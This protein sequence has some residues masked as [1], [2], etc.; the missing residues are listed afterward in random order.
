VRRLACG[1]L[2]LLSAPSSAFP[3]L[4]LRP[5][6]TPFE[7]PADAAPTAIWWN[8]AALA[9]LSGLHFQVD[10][11][12]LAHRG[13]YDRAA[14]DTTTGLPSPTGDRTFPRVALDDDRF[15]YF[16]G[17]VWDLRSDT[18][19]LGLALHAPWDSTLALGGGN[20]LALP[21]SYHLVS[22]T[23]RNIYV[24]L[25]IALKLDPHWMVGLTISAVD[26]TTDLVFDRDTALDG[27]GAG[28]RSPSPRC[29]NQPCGFENPA[30]AARLH[31]HGD[32]GAIRIDGKDVLPVP[33]GLGMTWG[34]LTHYDR[35]WMGASWSHVFP[36]LGH[37]SGYEQ[38]YETPSA[39][40]AEL[41]PAPG[42]GPV[43]G[44]GPCRGGADIAYS[45]PDVF[46]LGARILLTETLELSTWG[47]L[48]LY[49][50]YGTSR[51][52]AF[53]GL[54]VHL[55]G[56]PVTQGGAPEQIVLARGLRPAFAAEVGLRWRPI[57]PVRIGLSFIGESS[58]VPSDYVSAAAIDAPKVDVTVAAE[59]RPRPFHVRGAEW[60]FHLGVSYGLTAL[61]PMQPSPGAFDPNAR[62]RCVDGSY[63][64]DACADD[65]AGKG[66]PNAAG[67][68]SQILH[69]L[70][71]SVGLHF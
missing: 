68:Y 38:T 19:R 31:V 14:L 58:S 45:I 51:D 27:G 3:L 69:H 23:F 65:L 36:L 52:P 57:V 70:T 9:L 20:P 8:P 54:V 1:I 50:G 71:G 2:L 11:G 30:A 46:H 49:G 32:G 13:T 64:L 42:L 10:A 17:A 33:A 22:E 47:R 29:G 5:G 60:G 63:A 4:D 34:V 48:T 41:T 21:S 18:F 6:G 37:G 59:W 15:H 40:G 24:S 61:F 16:A 67:T 44:G 53:R 25:A 7:G 39:V 26:S 56:A 62:V 35:L 55:S 12:L 43:C 66:L 28:V